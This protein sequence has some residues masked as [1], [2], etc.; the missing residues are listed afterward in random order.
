MSVGGAGLSSDS[1]LP[2]RGRARWTLGQAWSRFSADLSSESERKE[3]ESWSKSKSNALAFFLSYSPPPHSEWQDTQ[4]QEDSTL[5]SQ[6]RLPS[7][8]LQRLR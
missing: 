3:E 2:L 1:L 6:V 8:P 4:H 5:I 7:L